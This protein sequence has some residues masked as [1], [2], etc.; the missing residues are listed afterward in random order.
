MNRIGRPRKDSQPV[1]NR[2]KI[3]RAT[4]D[5]IRRRGAGAVT[6]RNVCE[7][8]EVSIGTFY[9]Y[10]RNK[11]DLMMYFIKDT[12]WDDIA[13]DS[14]LSDIAG[15]ITELYMHLVKRYV[16]LGREFMKSFYTADNQALSAYMGQVDGGF[17][18]GTVMAFC[19]QQLN[20]AVQ[21]GILKAGFDTHEASEDIC[22]V[23]KGCV[24]E[25]CLSQDDIAV[26]QVMYRILQ[27][28]FASAM[29]GKQDV[30]K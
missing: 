23:V 1:D 3:I 29:T 12:S 5:L 8:A 4:V 15:R 16:E 26:D 14:P 17:S 7:W 28:Y 6:V 30:M 27:R 24:F 2:Q 22:T 19:E 18:D 20:L 10:F 25:W 9:H 11:D 13:W 21:Q